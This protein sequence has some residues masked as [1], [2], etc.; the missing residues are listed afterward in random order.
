MMF[1]IHFFFMSGATVD[2]SWVKQLAD[3]ANQIEIDKQEGQ[4]K[5]QEE[6]RLGA[7]AT[8]PFID[9]LYMLF[10][11]CSEEFN[12]H[13]M[14]PNLRVAVSRLNKKTKG[15]YSDLSIPSEE[16]AYFTFTRRNWMYGIRGINGIVDFCEF[17]VTEGASSLTMKLDELG[18]EA[19]YQLIAKV[20]GDP[21]DV[22]KKTVV[23]TYNDEIMDGPKLI[24]LCQHYFSEFITRTND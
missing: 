20:Q 11:A 6:E 22:S 17:P 2:F 8:V 10:Q 7:L 3:Q 18:L 13:S 15:S 1:Q 12:K 21:Q 16:I 14:F 24:S 9:K 4:R 23:W 19:S 5:K